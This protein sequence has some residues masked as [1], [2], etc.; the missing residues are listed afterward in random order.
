MPVH[1]VNDG[2]VRVTVLTFEHA[3]EDVGIARHVVASELAAP[4]KLKRGTID[5][6]KNR[7]IF[8]DT[9][10]GVDL[11]VVVVDLE[12]TIGD[13]GMIA[14]HRA[15]GLM[16]PG[17]HFYVVDV[18]LTAASEVK[19]RRTQRNEAFQALTRTT[20]VGVDHGVGDSGHAGQSFEPGAGDD[21]ASPNGEITL[22]LAR[23]SAHHVG[24]AG[25]VNI[26]T[27]RD[28]QLVACVSV[29]RSTAPTMHAFGKHDRLGLA[30]EF[31]PHGGD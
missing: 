31:F 4:G 13:A 15:V 28:G 26:F 12:E 21:T 6:V 27:G 16:P 9:V 22:V 11:D 29:V 10:V 19:M 20:A 14:G 24:P 2:G 5:L 17:E 23:E 25:Q 8:V 1:G 3:V 30:R 18:D 7:V